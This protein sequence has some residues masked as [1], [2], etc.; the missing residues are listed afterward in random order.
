MIRYCASAARP[1]AALGVILIAFGLLL[2]PGEAE[3]GLAEESTH[4]I[5]D[6]R[7]IVILFN[8]QDNPTH[9]PFTP[10]EVEGMM[11]GASGSVNSFFQE[12]SYGRVSISGTV[13]GWYT[14]PL[15]QGCN[16]V[17][18]NLREAIRAAD[19][20][21]NF[22]DYSRI[23]LF[24]PV[25]GGEASGGKVPVET[26]DG[27][28][29]CPPPQSG[30]CVSASW[31]DYNL[32]GGQLADYP[33]GLVHEFGHNF[34]R[35]HAN[36][37]N[38]GPAVVSTA[39]N[40]TSH[41]YGDFYSV[42]GF[43]TN[44]H[45]NAQEKEYL[46]WFDPSQIAT[47]T[48]PEQSGNYTLTPLETNSSERKT[49]KIKRGPNDWIFLEY[50]QPIGADTDLDFQYDDSDIYEGAFVHGTHPA[51]Q[52]YQSS[53][54]D[55][56][57]ADGADIWA[58]VER[59]TL[60]EGQTF[61]DPFTGT[62][63]TVTGRTP[64]TLTLNIIMGPC[65]GQFADPGQNPN[66]VRGTAGDDALTGT[67]GV[68][69][70]D[71]LGGNDE[72]HAMD[73]N[74]VICGGPGNDTLDGGAGNDT[75][76][77]GSAA[78]NINASLLSG[79]ASGEGDDTFENV[80]NL[81][82]SSFNDALTGNDDANVLHGGQGND[83]LV[84]HGGA[85]TLDGGAND[86]IVYGGNDGEVFIG[87]PGNDDLTGNG[88][89]DT[90][91]YS[92]A[93]G[94]VFV[95]LTFTS[96][97]QP[98]GGAGDDGL[99]SIENLTGSP[100]ND[101]LTGDAQPNTLNGGAANDVL[102][103]GDGDDIVNGE[104]GTD[105]LGGGGGTNILN[106]GAHDD[107][108]WGGDGDEVLVGGPGNDDLVGNGGVDT[109]D[110]SSAP[111]GVFVN[112]TLSGKQPTGGAGDDDLRTIENVT[113]SPFIDALTG[114][115]QGNTLSGGDGNDVLD[116]GGGSDVL[117]GEAGNDTLRGEAGDDTL[118]GGDGNDSM[119]GGAGSDTCNGGN[120]TDSKHGCE[121][122]SGVP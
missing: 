82:G 11:F 91:D 122:W 40:C 78:G 101:G 38:C 81:R 97:K 103:G 33:P 111:A 87:G 76:S 69:V 13:V 15:N 34:G 116:G 45:M 89:I 36:Y 88:G 29:P 105:H 37:L 100:F 39:A 43:Y 63:I 46:G 32:A 52:P 48:Q 59:V 25:C 27:T 94:G 44:G 56:S 99:S 113:G 16:G 55:M 5:G 12:I 119:F 65:V 26:A 120:G 85:N 67:S 41:E 117:N 106:G 20:D 28:F 62:A 9:K 110:Y 7:T 93:T 107:I 8:F 53:L 108:L 23:V 84:G 77:Y 92:S 3:V 109:A 86:D 30:L 61:T 83:H 95:D 66:F 49:V 51:S 6:Q 18:A 114:D 1:L 74:D 24:N 70:I 80:E 47:V 58:W 60:A 14:V 68:D 19:P 104:D 17:A 121:F 2:Y 90:A 4:V 35:G 79:T 118:N 73:G 112:L 10:L 42:M 115:A 57:P 21:V 54:W 75:V 96:G 31:I 22:Q 102:N 64:E 98:T 71:G 50:R 72:I